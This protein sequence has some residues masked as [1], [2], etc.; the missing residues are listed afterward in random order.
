MPFVV[1]YEVIVAFVVP[2]YT[3]FAAVIPEDH[4]RALYDALR[5]LDARGATTIV[6]EMADSVGIGVAVNDRLRRAA[7]R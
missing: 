7:H 1:P 5:S 4:A 2:S 3:L 6:C